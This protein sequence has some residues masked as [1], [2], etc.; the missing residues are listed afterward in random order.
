LSCVPNI[1]RLKVATSRE[2]NVVATFDY[3]VHP[4]LEDKRRKRRPYIIIKKVNVP[5]VQVEKGKLDENEDEFI[6]KSISFDMDS[7]LGLVHFSP[8]SFLLKEAKDF[9]SSESK[10]GE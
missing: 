1:V 8:R 4:M 9:D 10:D 7:Q 2:V 5:K 6:N 3:N